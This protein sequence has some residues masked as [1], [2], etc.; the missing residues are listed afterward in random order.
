MT[1]PTETPSPMKNAP[2][3]MD[4][5][6]IPATQRQEILL[7]AIIHTHQW[8][9]PRNRSYRQAV[10]AKGVGAL[11]TESHLTRI[12]RPTAHVFKSY[13]DLLPTPFPENHPRDFLQWLAHNL[14]IEF[15]TDRIQAFKTRYP[16]LEAFVQAIEH[17]FSDLGFVIGTSSGTSGKSTIMVRDSQGV[18]QAIEAYKLAVY[19]LWGTKDAHEIVFIMP[20]RT[21][22]VMAWLA[23]LATQHLGMGPQAHFGIPFPASPDH[24]RIRSGQLFKP[25]LRGLVEKRLLY[26]FMNKMN[27]TRVKETFVNRTITWLEDLSKAGKATLLFGG[28]VQLDAVYEGLVQRGYGINGKVLELNP[29]SMIGTGGG[30]KE[31]YPFTP[32]QIRER[33]STVLH[34]PGGEAVVH[35]DVYG[36]AE[37][38][39]AAAQCAYGNYH[40]PPWV[41]AVILDENDEIAP[42]SQASGL[43]AFFDPIAG[44]RLFPNFF[45]TADRVTLVNGGKWYDPGLTCPCGYQTS[46]IQR[47]SIARQDRLDEAGCAAQL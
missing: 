13:I 42:E 14:S 5:F 27:D 17:H 4:F 19:R 40:L 18:S 15:P 31:L 9:Y 20:E 10:E 26:P 35:R 8:H 16:S 39:W 6:G 11:V 22:I 46:Y 12:L 1:N 3:L 33:L 7:D 37:A 29:E 45:K 24:V 34:T 25:G 36:M 2:D 32:A 28:W 47:D 21:R 41:Y 30:V 38:N 44:G 43:L 23:R